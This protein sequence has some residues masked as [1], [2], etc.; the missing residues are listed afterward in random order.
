MTGNKM[1]RR[2]KIE[3]KLRFKAPVASTANITNTSIPEG[4]NPEEGEV[5]YATNGDTGSPCLAVYSG[6][7]WK[8]VVLG[9]TISA[10]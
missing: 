10:T 4:A 8:R 3:A 9:A 5:R 2:E 7:T 1:I 6:G